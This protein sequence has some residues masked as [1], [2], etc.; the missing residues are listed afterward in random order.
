LGEF[1][2]KAAEDS[3]VESQQM[4]RYDASYL[5]AYRDD[6]KREQMFLS[7][8]TEIRKYKLNG[9][10][11]DV[12]CGI[13]TFLDEFPNESWEKYGTDVSELAIQ[14]AR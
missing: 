4:V 2:N 5:S 3:R 9:R 8:L 11:L 6:P 7:E 1:E 12:G 10:I 14:Q 13:G